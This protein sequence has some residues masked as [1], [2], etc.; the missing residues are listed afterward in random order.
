VGLALAIAAPWYIKN[1]VLTGNPLFPLISSLFPSPYLSAARAFQFNHLAA[2]YHDGR[3]LVDFLLLLPKL[4][5]GYQPAATVGKLGFGGAIGGFLL[6]ALLGLRFRNGRERVVSGLFVGYGL[7]WAATSQHVRFL[8]PLLVLASLQGL[9]V[10][11]GLWERRRWVVWAGFVVVMLQSLVIAGWQMK[12]DRIDDLLLGR[13]SREQFL[14]HHLP[15]SYT[16]AQQINQVLDPAQH[17]VMTIGNY[18]RD[19]YFR[20]PTLSHTYYDTEYLDRAFKTDS[21]APEELERFLRDE[22]VTHL[23][24]NWQYYGSV[25]GTSGLVDIDAM[26]RYL[27]EHCRVVMEMGSVQLL[28]FE[29]PKT[30]GE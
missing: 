9:Q 29:W 19:Y 22:H 17:K 8:L 18:G 10:I 13:I 28:E 23:L 5:A 26:R 4:V 6:L 3:G 15:V 11:Q 24:M 27:S 20:V 2:N 25:H 1:W 14:G 16:M 7:F 21:V 12:R 30:S